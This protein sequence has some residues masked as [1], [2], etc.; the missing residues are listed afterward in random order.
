MF[1]KVETNFT[2]NYV[3]YLNLS[4]LVYHLSSIYPM[5][6]KKIRAA[7]L[8]IRRSSPTTRALVSTM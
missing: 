5:A 1:Y 6:Q 8:Q 2:F 3:L 4:G 7:S